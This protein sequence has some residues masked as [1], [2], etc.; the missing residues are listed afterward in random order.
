MPLIEKL[1][2]TNCQFETAETSGSYRYTVTEGREVIL[3]HPAE[4]KILKRETGLE[5][6]EARKRGLLRN[7]TYCLCYS[8]CAKFY[9]DIDRQ[10]K[11]C[12]TCMSHDVRTYAGA[13]AESCPSCKTGTLTVVDIGI[14]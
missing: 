12:A 6:D 11:Q 8:C 9:L 14:S 1:V 3:G 4:M 13:I 10:P 7:K 5:W 2:C